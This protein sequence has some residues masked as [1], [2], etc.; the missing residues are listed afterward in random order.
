MTK[1]CFPAKVLDQHAVW[2]GKT[3]SGKS[4]ALRGVVE[5][6]LDQGKRVCIVDPKGDW[7]GLKSSADGKSAG[8][9]VIAFGDFKEQKASDIPINAQSGKHVAELIVS[10]N[11]P[12]IIG[13]RGWMPGQMTDF[14]IDFASTLFNTNTGELFVVIDEVHNFAP[15]GKIMDPKAGK[16][17]HW[18][19]RLLSEGRG[20]GLVFLIASQR[21]QKVHN[22]ALTCCETLVAMRVNHAADRNALKEW[23]DGCGD[24]THGQQILNSVADMERGEAFVWSPEIKFG[25][26]RLKFPMFNTFDSFAPPQLQK[27][28][29]QSGWSEVDLEVVKEKLAAV[30]EESK[31]ND[32]RELKKQIFELRRQLADKP[33]SVA[34]VDEAAV[35]IAVRSAIET[36]RADM[37]EHFIKLCRHVADMRNLAKEVAT[38]AAEIV[39]TPVPMPP[40]LPEPKT[41]ISPV[42]GKS[43]RLT[44]PANAPPLSKPSIQTNSTEVS[45]SGP[46][47][48]ILIR[49]AE[50]RA[51][52]RDSVR[53]SWLAASMSTTVRSRGFEE[54]MR[55]LKKLELVRS[56]PP[57]NVQ[58]TESGRATAGEQL[59]LSG[60]ALLDKVCQM[61]SG[62]QTEILRHLVKTHLYI[63]LETLAQQFNT[64]V[65]ARGFEENVRFLRSNDLIETQNGSVGAADWLMQ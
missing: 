37:Q 27:K 12:C 23:I 24:K 34:Q 40:E 8:Y 64:T 16:V 13:F 17:L 25:P 65:R 45:L 58:L 60:A 9:P 39:G 38:K 18:T 54:N 5:N 52:G 36:T 59:P 19:N 28:V 49:L 41:R 53:L 4:S 20:L 22:D 32:P 46:Q 61:L 44:L 50:F 33:Q 63:P 51:C 11:R 31:A 62:P 35:E 3:G 57:E 30:I 47:H 55:Q 48:Q 29:S 6:L 7:W 14:W 42:S 15:K 10:G 43:F 21:P 2:L 26:Q 56:V 1:L